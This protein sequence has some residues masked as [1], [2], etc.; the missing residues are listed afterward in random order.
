M[1]SARAKRLIVAEGTL[2]RP[3]SSLERRR[4]RRQ[5]CVPVTVQEW[6]MLTIN[7]DIV[8][9]IIVQARA[10]DAKVDVVE[11][12]PGSNA[13]EDEMLEVIEDHPDD[14]TREVVTE[15]IDGLNVDEQA[16]LVALAWI[17]RGSFAKEEW[18]DAL[19]EARDQHKE[20]VAEYLLGM[21]LLGDYLAD[22]LAEFGRTCDE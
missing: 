13:A 7:P 17:G 4:P 3:P 1:Q 11:E 2:H 6:L 16:E 20:R 22:G 8:C 21:P 5:A 12:D 18:E 19:R 14:A 15:F 9:Q 10:I